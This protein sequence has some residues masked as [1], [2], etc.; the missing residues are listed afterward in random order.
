[1]EDGCPLSVL[2]GSRGVLLSPVQPYSI[3]P[4]K[5][6]ARE[7]NNCTDCPI[8]AKP[9]LVP[10]ADGT[11]NGLPPSSSAIPIV[12]DIPVGG[13]SSSDYER[14]ITSDRLAALR[15][16]LGERGLPPKVIELILGAARSNTHSAYQSAW[17]A[18]S[19]WCSTRKADPMSASAN[20]VLTFLSD[21]FDSGM[22]YSSVNVARSMLSTTF[23]LAESSLDIGRNP[24]VSKLMK[25]IY[26]I[27]PPSPKYVSTWDPSVVLSYFDSTAG[28][29][30][31][32]LQL[33]RRTATLLALNSLSRCAD[34]ASIQLP[35][36]R[37]S[38]G[39]V[40]F[41]L[42]RPRKAQHSGPLHSLSVGAWHQNLAICPNAFLKLYIDRTAPL[43]N[44][45]N[46][47]L[48]FI[49]CNK[50]HRP[51]SSSTIGRWIK[52]QLKEAGIDTS[53]FSAHSA[54]GAAASKAMAQGIPIQSIL[55]Q[56]HWARESTFAKFYKRTVP[57][58][59]SDVGQAVLQDLQNSSDEE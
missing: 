8:L 52:D 29:S 49:G 55:N 26:N 23:G 48:L 53:I 51:V 42:S 3:L 44:K 2:E 57:S 12:A 5:D 1:M 17:N 45:E 15:S 39:D 10:I 59:I 46:D 32:I 35:S 19:R 50:P 43:R 14:I 54:R 33:A 27:K 38:D 11:S 58:N 24:L 21:Y 9:A 13:G 25:G 56:G 22:S 7:G 16:C 47:A 37:F 34:L 31:S 36:I 40:S 4:V 20:D 30:F 41:S 6:T 18:W 28:T